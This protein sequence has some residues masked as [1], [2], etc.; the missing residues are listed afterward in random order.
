MVVAKAA[1]VGAIDQRGA[2]GVQFRDKSIVAPGVEILHGIG[3]GQVVRRGEARKIRRSRRVYR[4]G[5]RRIGAR[6]AQE[7]TVGDRR[8]DNQRQRCIVLADRETHGFTRQD[9]PRIHGNAPAIAFLVYD[10]RLFAKLLGA[11]QD[12]QTAIL[13]DAQFAAAEIPYMNGRKVRPRS[14]YELGLQVWS[15]APVKHVD[16][17]IEIP[18]YDARV[19]GLRQQPSVLRPSQEIRRSGEA[20]SGFQPG[21]ANGPLEVH[22]EGFARHAEQHFAGGEI[23]RQPGGL[24]HKADRRR[25]LAMV[26]QKEQRHG[27]SSSRTRG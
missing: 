18:I 14:H 6:P 13:S 27:F 3:G 10:G 22:A 9:E 4:Q 24:C 21:S 20:V 8:I 12:R 1:E 26:R 19:Q 11:G 23:G 2:R 7:R 5:V 17:R 25:R 15:G 16:S